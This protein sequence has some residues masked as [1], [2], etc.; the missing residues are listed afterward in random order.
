MT[1]PS[2]EEAL[3]GL[4]H[5][6]LAWRLSLNSPGECTLS[7]F[8]LAT[9]GAV[10]HTW[11]NYPEAKV[12]GITKLMNDAGFPVGAYADFV[13]YVWLA[14]EGT[15]TVWDDKQVVLKSDGST[16]TTVDGI[17]VE[18][19][20]IQRVVTSVSD[21]LV[22]HLIAAHLADGTLQTLLSHSDLNAWAN[23]THNC[24]DHLMEST[25]HWELATV[26]AAFAGK[27]CFQSSGNDS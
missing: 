7:L 25:W 10:Q 18:V 12:D 19:E 8:S 2:I 17:V 22:Q 20:S 15:L 14:E 6:V 24:N 21:D 27:R 9:G 16:I 4:E 23:P 1:R 13:D 26:I 5:K 11:S 3:Y